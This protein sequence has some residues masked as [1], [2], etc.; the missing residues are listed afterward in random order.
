MFRIATAALVLGLGSTATAH[1]Q[2]MRFHV[3][4]AQPGVHKTVD[5]K[6]GGQRKRVNLV[7]DEGSFE[8]A[9]I[10]L[11]LDNEEYEFHPSCRPHEC[12]MRRIVLLI[13]EEGSVDVHLYDTETETEQQLFACR[14][15]MS[16]GPAREALVFR[17]P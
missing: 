6:F 8:S 2:D 10:T 1:S 12:A 16:R 9:P 5:D 13:G 11:T 17:A 7:L 3:E 4:W 15:S 14:R